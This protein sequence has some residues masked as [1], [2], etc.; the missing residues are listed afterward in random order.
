MHDL[1]FWWW[2]VPFA[3]VSALVFALL[4]HR[5]IMRAAPGDEQRQKIAGFVAKGHL[6]T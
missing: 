6:H 1:P 2:L 3:A 5:Q 4:F